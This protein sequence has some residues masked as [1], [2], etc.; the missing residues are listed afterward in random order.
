MSETINLKDKN[1]IADLNVAFNDIAREHP[2]VI[3]FLEMYCGFTTPLNISD[4]N[5]ISY[6]SGKRDVILMIK[7]LMRNDILPE[8]IAQYY[9]RNL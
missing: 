5:E 1:C 8:Q 3:A 6:S 7:T 4:P 9:E 2:N